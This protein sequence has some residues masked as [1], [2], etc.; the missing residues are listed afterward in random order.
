MSTHSTITMKHADG[1]YTQVYCHYDGYMSRV[2]RI[3]MEHYQNPA[4]IEALV[5]LGDL[6]SLAPE[7]ADCVAYHRDRGEIMYKLRFRDALDFDQS[8]TRE[9]YNYLWTTETGWTCEDDDGTF[10]RMTA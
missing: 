1:T 2:G 9:E 3:L 8:K 6:S 5:N 4:K 7:L 10:L